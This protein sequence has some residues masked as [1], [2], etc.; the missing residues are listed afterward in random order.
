MTDTFFDPHQRATV[1]AAMARMIPTDDAPGAAEAGTIDFL[2]RYLSGPGYVYA[3][4]D[5]SGFE[6]LTGRR[7]DAWTRR[8]ELVRERYVAGVRA[9]DGAARKRGADFVDLEPDAQDDVLREVERPEGREQ[10]AD[11]AR[12]QVT[13][14]GAPV[15]TALQQTSAE[16]DLGFVPLLALHT[17]QGFYADPVYGGNRDQVGWQVI[18]FPVPASLAEVH[19]G[20]YTTIDYFAENR[21]HPGTED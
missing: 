1:A 3:T 2:D 20:R 11:M 19:Q 8:I 12:S 15:E 10:E 5:G 4:P 6:A 14:Y 18:G 17:R 16:V 9:L 21:V 13:L 7:L